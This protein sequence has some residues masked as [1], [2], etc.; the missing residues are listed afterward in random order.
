MSKFTPLPGWYTSYLNDPSVVQQVG[1]ER[2]G[3]CVSE[4][5]SCSATG[6]VSG[7]EVTSFPVPCLWSIL[8]LG[9]QPVP[10]NLTV[11]FSLNS[12]D[13][14]CSSWDYS[15]R[16]NIFPLQQGWD[17]RVRD[18][19][20]CS[21]GLKV[22]LRQHVLSSS[23]LMGKTFQ[24]I[25]LLSCPEQGLCQGVKVVGP[26]SDSRGPCRT[27]LKP[28]RNPGAKQGLVLVLAHKASCPLPQ[29]CRALSRAI[30]TNS[31]ADRNKLFPELT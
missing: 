4:R 27:C 14:T 21:L 31:V 20:P 9:V 13:S 6:F 26:T 10:S 12:P 23:Q 1:A 29:G 16:G 25:C 22:F 28:E 3:R 2:P 30:D 8:G 7:V 17:W 24:S 11:F 5:C 19:Q 18:S 15:L